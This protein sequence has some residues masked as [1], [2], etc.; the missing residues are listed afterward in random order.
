MIRIEITDN[1]LEERIEEKKPGWLQRARQ[2]ASA[3]SAAGEVGEG[4]GI[5][6][7]IKEVFILLQQF[8]CIYCESLMPKVES[9]SAAMVG[10]DY[11]IEHY[12][13]KNR[14]TGWPSRR[15]IKRRLRLQSYVGRVAS[16]SQG[17]YPRLAFDPLNYVVSCKVCNSSYKADHF[18]IAG[19]PGDQNLSI[20]D[21]NITERPL[22]LFPF[23]EFG[24]DPRSYFAFIGPLIHPQRGP[25]AAGILRAQLVIDFFELDTREGLLEG[26]CSILLLLWP[27]LEN[28]SSPDPETRAQAEAFLAVIKEQRRFEHTACGRAFIELH[29]RDHPL[30]AA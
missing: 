27:Q 6:S 24:D 11:D 29:E 1:L 21:L 23:G 9:A 3:A 22:L 13:P 26:R 4:D 16:G 2:R 19:M 14:V 10:V 12:R 30:A 5:W 8:K 25:G 28:R 18:P 17:G 7:E 20:A 15:D